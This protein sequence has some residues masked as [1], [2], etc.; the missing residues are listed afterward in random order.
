MRESSAPGWAAY[1]F[2]LSASDRELDK[3]LLDDLKRKIQPNPMLLKDQDDAKLPGAPWDYISMKQAFR[4]RHKLTIR[5]YT[6]A[7]LG[8]AILVLPMILMVLLKNTVAGLVT[9]AGCA[10]MFAIASAHLFSAKLDHELIGVTAAYAAV[11]VVFV[12]SSPGQTGQ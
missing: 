7:G 3:R 1:P 9:V 2:L 8:A 11:L 4:T 12:G 6:L 10:I 5:R